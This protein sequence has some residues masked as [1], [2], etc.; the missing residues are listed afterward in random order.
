MISR[1][2]PVLLL[3]ATLST[4]FGQAAPATP[5]VPEAVPQ[6]G[7]VPQVIQGTADAPPP[8][9]ILPS[10]PA[11]PTLKVPKATVSKPTSKPVIRSGEVLTCMIAQG[12][13]EETVKGERFLVLIGNG[14]TVKSA[15][16]L[17]T[18]TTYADVTIVNHRSWPQH[19]I[20]AEFRI[21][22]AQP[23]Y[24]RLSYVDPSKL[25][26]AKGKVSTKSKGLPP[27][28]Y[29]TSAKHLKEKE[30][31]AAKFAV[32]PLPR[33]VMKPNEE[34][35]GRVYFQAPGKT[36]T[37]MSLILP[38]FGETFEFPYPPPGNVPTTS[39]KN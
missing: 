11:G 37:S 5:S 16:N 3:A 17:D 39:V 6:T 24:K 33:R 29:F 9:A 21:D 18:D 15:L 26:L 34:V 32:P 2:L 14:F 31:L 28:S 25:G 1:R 19:L 36:A 38:I 35:T 12:C 13:T 8:P 4:A 10:A 23:A 27:P 22:V 30:E 20:P 7:S